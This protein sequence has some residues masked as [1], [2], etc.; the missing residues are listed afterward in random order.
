MDERIGEGVLQWFGHVVRLE[1]DITAKIVYVGECAGSCSA[2]RPRKKRTDT[3]K[4]YLK[5]E[6][7][8]G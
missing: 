5:K 7:G 8:A 1:T 6:N 3:V 2:A 4:E